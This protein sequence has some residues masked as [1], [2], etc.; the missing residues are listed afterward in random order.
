MDRPGVATVILPAHGAGDG[1]VTVV[2][3]LAVAAYALRARGMT[4]D[5]LLLDDGRP[6]AAALAAR[7]A[8][9]VRPSSSSRTS[10]A[11]PRAR[12]A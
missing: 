12:R 3:D 8:A 7:A 4:L 2:R 6:P 11:T 5:V 9:P 10:R 1:L